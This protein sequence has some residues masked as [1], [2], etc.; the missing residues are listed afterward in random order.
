MK[1]LL[2]ILLTVALLMSSVGLVAFAAGDETASGDPTP[3][4]ELDMSEY[5]AENPVLKDKANDA[6]ITLAPGS[7]AQTSGFNPQK[8]SYTALNGTTNSYMTFS[9]LTSPSDNWTSAGT[10][11]QA[12]IGENVLN[13]D[14]LTFEFWAKSEGTH[15]YDRIFSYGNEDSDETAVELNGADNGK[16][17]AKFC[18]YGKSNEI[19]LSYPNNHIEWGSH[20][21]HIVMTSEWEANEGNATKMTAVVYVDGVQAGST[22]ADSTDGRRP[23]NESKNRTLYI[24]GNNGGVA[25]I[26]N[27]ASFKVYNKSL[28]AEQVK[29]NYYKDV[30]NVEQWLVNADFSNY[31]GSRV[32]TV[33]DKGTSASEFFQTTHVDKGT[34]INEKG[35][36]V[37]YA[38]GCSETTDSTTSY[39]RFGFKDDTFAELTEQTISFWVKMPPNKTRTWGQLLC[40][41]HKDPGDYARFELEPSYGSEQTG[42]AEGAS[43]GIRAQGG[44][45]KKATPYY[46]EV[47][48]DTWMNIT[49]TKSWSKNE[50][51]QDQVTWN[52]YIDGAKIDGLSGTDC[53]Y[54]FS[55]NTE[56]PGAERNMSGFSVFS[57][58]A[59][60]WKNETEGGAPSDVSAFKV[61][62]AALTADQIAALYAAE[63][64]DYKEATV[65]VDK[66]FGIENNTASVTVNLTNKGTDALNVDGWQAILAAYSRDRFVKADTATFSA[67]DN[68]TF[69]ATASI[70]DLASDTRY[71]YKLFVWKADLQPLVAAMEL[72]ANA[73]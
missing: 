9:P 37:N 21:H 5:T 72:S 13:Q 16:T 47:P 36:A 27:L 39:G 54:S 24:G 20:W 17:Y 33:T 15:S 42:G 38:H 53:L 3:V 40:H 6:V 25:F 43:F 44:Q 69:R 19:S 55:G 48:V 1:K 65:T 2:S 23:S 29:A 60:N 66:E 26:G 4:F 63:K 73:D 56:T 52:T 31:D 49:V 35:R 58:G 64:A 32:D 59:K 28:T 34:Y 68:G 10:V 22:T 62:Q 61:C 8:V 57:F 71:T 12:A 41:T 45:S 50:S 46:I 11:A 18:F 70:G 30:V 51:N 14:E 7:G 67:S